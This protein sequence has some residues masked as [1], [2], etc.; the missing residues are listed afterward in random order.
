MHDPVS[1]FDLAADQTVEL[2]NRLAEHDAEA[3]LWDIADGLLAGA[4]HFW[5]HSR[6]PCDRPDCTDCA[7]I[8]TAGLRLAELKRLC[9]ELARESDYFHTPN[10]GNAGHA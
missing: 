5:L 10:D 3:D 7:P 6:Q 1:P 4:I 8:S 2:G 9:D